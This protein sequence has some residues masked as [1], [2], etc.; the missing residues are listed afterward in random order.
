MYERILNKKKLVMESVRLSV[1]QFT[2]QNFGRYYSNTQQCATADLGTTTWLAMPC[3][4]ELDWICKI[5]R[6]TTALDLFFGPILKCLLIGLEHTS[7]AY[8]FLFCGTH[9]LV[10]FSS[11]PFSAPGAFLWH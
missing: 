2:Y 8:L 7:W 1:S 6:G 5:P 3:D 9:F 10:I 11:L 4:S